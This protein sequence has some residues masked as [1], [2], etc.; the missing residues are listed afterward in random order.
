MGLRVSPYKDILILLY[1]IPHLMIF[2]K[3]FVFV[4]RTVPF[5]D[6]CRLSRKNRPQTSPAMPKDGVKFHSFHSKSGYFEICET[7]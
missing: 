3:R 7:L 6:F 1:I 4:S 5:S 2:F